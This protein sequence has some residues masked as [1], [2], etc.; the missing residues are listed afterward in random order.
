MPLVFHAP[1][2]PP[3]VSRQRS[4]DALPS[5]NVSDRMRQYTPRPNAP[6][7][8]IKP[9][10]TEESVSRLHALAL[11]NASSPSGQ[12]NIAPAGPMTSPKAPP[13]TARARKIALHGVKYAE[14]RSGVLS[15]R[16]VA[17]MKAEALE[18][19]ALEY[20]RQRALA[21][22]TDPPQP[23]YW[24]LRTE[25]LRDLA[26][27]R[28]LKKPG[29]T[30]KEACGPMGNKA[31]IISA[32][33]KLDGISRPPPSPRPPVTPAVAVEQPPTVRAAQC[34]Q[35]IAEHGVAYAEAVAASGAQSER[36]IAAMKATALEEAAAEFHRQRILLTFEVRY[37]QHARY[38][39]ARTHL[40]A[41]TM[42][43]RSHPPLAR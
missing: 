31:N 21:P 15:E 33:R 41:R 17:S 27:E 42:R 9:K 24:E 3:F 19:A 13:P 7:P 23:G 5:G 28:G 2:V 8:T 37:A 43:M 35:R 18:A 12:E 14:A 30:W 22:D 11:A 36:A 25:R 38:G 29:Q 1:Q 26:I 32:L 39:H 40:R 4:I 10:I 6:T 20:H 34:A 16:T